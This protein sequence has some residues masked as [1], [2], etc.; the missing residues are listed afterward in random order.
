MTPNST[1]TEMKYLSEAIV[2]KF[3]RELKEALRAEA[4]TVIEN[5]ANSIIGEMNIR[6]IGYINASKM[7]AEI[8][9][10]LHDKRAK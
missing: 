8:I 6:S 3:K 9:I 5:A 2:E 10:E 1:E 7:V 4:E